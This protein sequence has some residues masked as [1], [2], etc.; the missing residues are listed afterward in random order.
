MAGINKSYILGGG[1]VGLYCAF[2]LGWDVITAKPENVV[3]YLFLHDTEYT[4]RF[5]SELNVDF[6][7]DKWTIGFSYKG[8]LYPAATPEMVE[9]YHEKCYG[10]K[11]NKPQ[12]EKPYY[13]ILSA[14]Y[15]HVHNTLVSHANII[16]DSVVKIDLQNKQL[17]LEGGGVLGY[18]RVISTIPFVNMLDM[19]G[20]NSN[21]FTYKPIYISQQPEW[22]FPEQYDTVHIMDKTDM[23]TRYVKGTVQPDTYY[24][25]SLGPEP[26]PKSCFVMKYG[27]IINSPELIW[28]RDKLL[29]YLA[30]H[31]VY[32]LGRFAKWT[33]HYDT[34]DALK[35]FD[36]LREVYNV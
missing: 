5:L 3:P 2:K 36:T 25:E 17:Y 20:L 29:N 35:D 24:L 10:H 33:Q 27:K 32:S 1:M 26:Q 16:Y 12:F 23:R 28:F 9:E 19:V 6:T 4:R 18:S 13:N 15:Y 7:E 14:N 22:P 21:V 11:P 8:S 34:Q 30:I 31:K